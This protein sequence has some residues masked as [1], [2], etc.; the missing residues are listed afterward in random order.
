MMA[1]MKRQSGR[2]WGL[3]LGAG[4]VLIA[5]AGCQGTTPAKN[6]TPNAISS[7]GLLVRCR[8]YLPS[9]EIQSGYVDFNLE[10]E[11]RSYR[12][13]ALPSTTLYVVDP[14]S[15]HFSPVHG[16]FGAV[17]NEL[18]IDFNGR[19]YK[20][21]FPLAL[22]R[23]DSIIVKPHHIVSI[24]ILE[25]RLERVSG[26]LEPQVRFAL[27]EDVRTRRSL[28]EEMIHR[29][30]DKNVD[31]ETRETAVAWSRELQEALVGLEEAQDAAPTYK[32]GPR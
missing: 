10:S 7:S 20:I 21:P 8:V 14:D 24:G 11:G 19:V 1:A 17:K 31:L 28:V 26:S 18:A 6:A 29:M 15:Y 4:V 30:M 13:R 5:M 27:L 2:S 3:L 9:G 16:V 25:A 32:P 23:H 12:V 22:L